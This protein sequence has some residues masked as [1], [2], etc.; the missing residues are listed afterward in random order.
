[1]A[2][3]HSA[4]RHP[5]AY[6]QLR[7]AERRGTRLRVGARRACAVRMSESAA[8][9]SPGGAPPLTEEENALFFEALCD[10]GLDD[11]AWLGLDEPLLLGAGAW[12]ACSA[13]SGDNDSAAAAGA[14]S[15]PSAASLHLFRCLDAAHGGTVRRLRAAARRGRRRRLRAPA[16]RQRPAGSARSKRCRKGLR[17]DLSKLQ[18]EKGF[19]SSCDGRRTQRAAPH[20]SRNAIYRKEREAALR[21]A[22]GRGPR[23]RRDRGVAAQQHPRR[24]RWRQ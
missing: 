3:P 4:R 23:A 2:V 24:Q 17:G 7:V 11:A 20:A 10:G 14:S 1:M 16:R 18:A 15:A 21:P 22:P 13:A 8:A 9:H 5:G 19:P 6:R 12:A